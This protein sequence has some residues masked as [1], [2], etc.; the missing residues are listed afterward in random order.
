L[1][2][3]YGQS[4]GQFELSSGGV[5]VPS[6]LHIPAAAR[7]AWHC[8][9]S[10]PVQVIA[11]RQIWHAMIVNGFEQSSMPPLPLPEPLPLPLPI[12][13]SLGQPDC[14]SPG[15]HTPLWLHVGC[16][17]PPQSTGQLLTSLDEQI[18]SPH[19]APPVVDG[20]SGPDVPDPS[21]QL[22][23]IA[24]MAA[25]QTNPRLYSFLIM[26]RNVANR[27]FPINDNLRTRLGRPL[28]S[29]L[30]GAR[31]GVQRV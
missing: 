29:P 5:H 20:A 25:A 15:S 24:T 9:V 22:Q 18:P 7:Q 21:P 2:R 6:K 10:L 26:R 12:M 27:R 23:C 4:C 17:I 31:R 16:V 3:S 1:L 8:W 13:Q 28:A 30:R 14:V 19:T 11:G